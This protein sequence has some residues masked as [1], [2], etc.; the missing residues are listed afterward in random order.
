M[1]GIC[2]CKINNVMNKNKIVKYLNEN[3]IILLIM[4]IAGFVIAVGGWYIQKYELDFFFLGTPIIVIGIVL[5]LLPL[6]IHVNGKDVYDYIE[7]IKAKEL[8]SIKDKI[9]Q[10]FDSLDNI[11]ARA[12]TAT[13]K[14]YRYFNVQIITNGNARLK[15]FRANQVISTVGEINGFVLEPDVDKLFIYHTV[16]DVLAES[17]IEEVYEIKC[18]EIE[19]LQAKPY[20]YTENNLKCEQILLSFKYGEKEFLLTL[21]DDL[22]TTEYIDM[23]NRA[24]CENKK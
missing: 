9:E 15:R 13:P 1:K 4:L 19:N 6:I 2:F 11:S 23:I 16:I 14:N 20:C 22:K 10:K 5:F 3:S 18:S 8:E 7:N 17:K 21:S 12:V 24:I